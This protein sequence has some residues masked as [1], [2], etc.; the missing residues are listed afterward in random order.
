[1]S[2]SPNSRVLTTVALIAGLVA[3]LALP[4]PSEPGHEMAEGAEHVLGRL[5]V[6]VA[7]IAEVFAICIIAAGIFRAAFQCLRKRK[8]VGITNEVRIGL[9]R[10]L[11]LALEFTIA[12]DILRTAVAPSRQALATLTIVVLL[13]TL[14]THF[15][16]EEIAAETK[17]EMKENTA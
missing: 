15:L 4:I 5:A 13:R 6:V 11:A 10:A 9:A 2:S 1:M 14:I 7:G 17:P 16:G 3:L 8:Q 12:S